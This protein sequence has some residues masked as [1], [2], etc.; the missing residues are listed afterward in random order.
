MPTRKIVRILAAEGQRV[1]EGQALA[2]IDPTGLD[3]SLRSAEANYQAQKVKLDNLKAKPAD[4]DAV[5]AE[6]DVASAKATAETAQEGYD[7]T[8]ALSDKGLAS[9]NQLAD[10]ERQLAA[11]RT[12]LQA[13]QL[14]WQN[15]KA[16]SQEDQIAAQESALTQADN[17]RQMARIVLDSAMIRSPIAGVVAEVLVNVGD[18]VSPSSSIATVV[19]PDPM[20]LQAQVNEN[21]M[22]N[23]RVGEAAL[24]TPSGYPDLRLA[25]KVTQIDLHAAVVN[26]VS[27]F[28]ATIEVPNRDGKLLWGMNA[29]A[30]ISVLS[31]TNVLTLPSSAIKTAN[32]VP[33]VTILDE[34]KLVSWDIQTGPSDGSRTQVVAGLDEGQL[35]VAPQRRSSTSSAQ[36]RTTGA[37]L[38]FLPGMR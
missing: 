25:G 4:L 26:N 19:D 3:L 13:T 5:T 31:L 21:D 1:K 11:A 8:K 37:R 34:G 7:N 24:V 22:A 10:A 28:T 38:P 20:W 17:D 33:Q 29:D 36:N 32:G 15:A 9:R 16:Q 6:A 2:E 35:V 23:V 30:E 18:L 27:V 14:I 12:K